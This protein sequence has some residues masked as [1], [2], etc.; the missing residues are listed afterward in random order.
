MIDN[1][2][3]KNLLK[4]KRAYKTQSVLDYVLR[5]LTFGIFSNKR[6]LEVAKLEYATRVEEHFRYEEIIIK[7]EQLEK[8][9]NI[10]LLNNIRLGQETNSDINVIIKEEYGND[11]DVIREAILI[12]DSYNCQ[13]SDGYCNGVLQVHHITP[14]S[15]GGTNQSFNLITLCFYHHSL[16]H[17]HMKNKL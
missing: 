5:F 3:Y 12:R 10:E 8:L 4:S 13:E 2:F 7:S 1:I 11:W 14:L 16:K 9:P 6:R 17:E 15:K